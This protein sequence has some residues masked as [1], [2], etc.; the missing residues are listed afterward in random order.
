MAP[1]IVSLHPAHDRQSLETHFA[2]L[3]G[4]DLRYR[5]FV[6]INP[7]SVNNYLDQL[8]VNGVHSYGI[9]GPLHA[10]V[11]TCQLALSEDDLEVGVS[12]LPAFRRQGLA[13]ALLGRSANHARARG[14]KAL[15]MHSL[16]DNVPMLSLARH[17]GMTVDRSM[18]IVD[19]RMLLRAET[20][21]CG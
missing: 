9:F 12:V 7:S 14:L 1:A 20:V 4:E 13:K 8:S 18:G 11:A 16:A 3:S 19:G 21:H 10:L 5:F 15:I 2:A 6:A 17:F